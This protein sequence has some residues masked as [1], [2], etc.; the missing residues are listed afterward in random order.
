V[1]AQGT[2]AP[3]GP[4]SE[5]D[6]RL[7]ELSAL[8]PGWFVWAV[9]TPYDPQGPVCWCAYP[10]D[11]GRAAITSYDADALV[12]QAQEFRLA[13]DGHVARTRRELADTEDWN[14]SRRRMLEADLAAFERLSK[15]TLA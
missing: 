9:R 7:K 15:E 11:A 1:N 8:M 6:Q 5:V 14:K 3:S 10:E 2:E 13:I 4:T 12:A